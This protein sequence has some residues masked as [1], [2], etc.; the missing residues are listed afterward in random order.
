MTF[1]PRKILPMTIDPDA[2]AREICDAILESDRA[3][4]GLGMK[5]EDVGAGRVTLSMTVGPHMINGHQICHGGFVFTLADS[6]CAIASNSRNQNMVLQSS[7]ITYLNPAYEGDRLTAEGTEQVIRG[8]SGIID[9]AV[10]RQDG[11]LV[12]MFRGVVR[13]IPGHTLPEHAPDS[14]S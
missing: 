1:T 5:V 11:T 7:T 9:V 3:T 12:A 8:R 10:S 4:V 2:L 13:S 14:A 6:A